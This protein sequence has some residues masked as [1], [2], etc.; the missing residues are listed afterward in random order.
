M[1]W[2]EEIPNLIL[3]R[4]VCSCFFFLSKPRV[5]NGGLCTALLLL[6]Q[7]KSKMRMDGLFTY[8]QCL[9]LG[10]I[11]RGLLLHFLVI[12]RK[13]INNASLIIVGIVSVSHFTV[14]HPLHSEMI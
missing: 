13:S 11:Q 4:G 7:K 8:R 2:K 6:R 10:L 1:S 12:S 5:I 3:E 14:S 9:P